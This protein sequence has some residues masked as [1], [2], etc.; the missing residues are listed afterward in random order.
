MS[1]FY[2]N[3]GVPRH[4]QAPGHHRN[5]VYY[6]RLLAGQSIAL[7]NMTHSTDSGHAHIAATQHKHV[8]TITPPK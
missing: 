8:A 7:M 5:T 2:T 3:L 4:W 6:N 1:Y